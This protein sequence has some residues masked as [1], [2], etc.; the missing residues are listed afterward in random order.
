MQEAEV[1]IV[2]VSRELEYYAS[3]Y[4]RLTDALF[5]I[6]GNIFFANNAGLM[7]ILSS[8]S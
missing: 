7:A 8:H 4:M 1:S 2:L 3:Y 6:L 5:I